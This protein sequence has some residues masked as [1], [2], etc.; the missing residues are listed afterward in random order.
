MSSELG[1]ARWTVMELFMADKHLHLP[2]A[3]MLHVLD[4]A[5]AT[6]VQHMGGV[7]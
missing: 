7:Q 1:L 5:C 4:L 2:A 3:T 6:C